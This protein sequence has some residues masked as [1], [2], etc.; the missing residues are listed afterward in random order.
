MSCICRYRVSSW[1]LRSSASVPGCVRIA[2]AGGSLRGGSFVASILIRH[3]AAV[4][5]EDVTRDHRR[6]LRGE[7][8]HGADDL[9]RL[10]EPAQRDAGGDL[11]R[12]VLTAAEA[13]V[14]QQLL[15]A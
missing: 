13:R 14:V 8:H 6:R 12:Q 2:I 11:R 4:E 5:E 1:S 10:A 15:E 9:L 7:E 3:E